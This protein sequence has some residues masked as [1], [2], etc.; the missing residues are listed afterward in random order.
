MPLHNKICSFEISRSLLR[1]VTSV[2]Q[3]KP[4]RLGPRTS[5]PPTMRETPT[6]GTSRPNGWQKGVRDLPRRAEGSS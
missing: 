2:F 5:E 3:R 1:G 4:E 6:V